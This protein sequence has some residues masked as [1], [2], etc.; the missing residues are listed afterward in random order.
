M[1]TAYFS[2]VDINGHKHF[3]VSPD[4]EYELAL[5]LAV[6]KRMGHCVTSKAFRGLLLPPA[7]NPVRRP[8]HKESHSAHWRTVTQEPHPA[9]ST[10]QNHVGE[11]VLDLKH[12]RVTKGL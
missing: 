7:Q 11:A 12:S 8:P 1:T 6:S 4:L 5:G 10:S 3:V 9:A 2:M